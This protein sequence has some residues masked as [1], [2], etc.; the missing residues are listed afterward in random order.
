MKNTGTFK[1]TNAYAMQLGAFFGIYWSIAFFVLA[2]GFAGNSLLQL[3]H[4]IMMMSIPFVGIALA[5]YFERQVRQD[6]IVTF[7]RGWL[8]GF[9]LYFYAGVIHCVVLYVYF[10]FYDHGVFFENYLAF[11]NRPENKQIL[12]APEF[13]QQMEQMLSAAGFSSLE[14]AVKS[15]T[16]IIIAGNVLDVN[17]FIAII[18][19]IPTA[20]FCKTNKKYLKN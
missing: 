17:T 12:E 9:L 7:G 8:F 1:Q 16:P 20:V 10:R 2:A 5:K 3:L 6:G 11:L 13:K 14:E 4:F 19:A 18:L 15:F